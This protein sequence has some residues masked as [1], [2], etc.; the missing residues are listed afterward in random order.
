MARVL[1]VDDDPILARLVEKRLSREGFELY[2]VS[3]A[4]AAEAALA[5]GGV[6]VVV[7]DHYL[8]RG[9]GLDILRRLREAGSEIPAIYVTGSSEATVA[10]DALKA[11][12]DDYVIKSAAD[13]FVALLQ[14]AITLAIEKAE[15]REARARADAET[16][17]A[18]ERAEMLLAEV[19]HRVA[20]SLS[21]VTSLLRLQASASGS[22]EVRTALAEAQTRI[23]A[24][25]GVHR[26][27]YLGEDVQT[28][29]LDAYLDSLL[30]DFARTLPGN[31]R[32]RIEAEPVRISADRAV[33]LGILV[34]E[35]ATNAA[36]YA[37][38]DGREGQLTIGIRECAAGEA[39]LSVSDD[40]VG[41]KPGE[42]QGTGL[43]RKLV[44]AMAERLEGKVEIS[45]D[46]KGTSVAL[47]F[48]I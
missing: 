21:M 43:G 38:P 33:N 17:A 27:L 3:D 12:A 24:V 26:G 39:L 25:A 4:E 44:V 14:R 29:L 36:K 10:I 19:H 11:G 41:S 47:R 30:R 20:N 31:V 13:D 42:V 15:L 18:R 28:I 48:P 7:L 34:S 32:M 2:H 46:G 45:S 8:V 35:L 40:G 23:A 37:W 6:G 22:D 16:R 9:T 5:T 1:Y